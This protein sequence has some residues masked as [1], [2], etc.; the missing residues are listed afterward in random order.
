MMLRSKKSR[1]NLVTIL[2]SLVAVV[3]L[4]RA[5]GWSEVTEVFHRDFS[6][7]MLLQFLVLSLAVVLIYGYRW[8]ML[9]G[10]GLTHKASLV[11]SVISLGG[12]MFLP[13]RG[14]DVLRVHYSRQ[15]M[16]MPYAALLSR[17]F[18]EKLIDVFAIATVGVVAAIVLQD[19]RASAGHS[20]LVALTVTAFGAVVLATVT[21][22]YFSEAVL[23]RIK[24]VFR[25][26]GKLPLF[27][28]H[29]VHL[30][31]DASRSL[32]LRCTMPPFILTLA[33][34]FSVYALAYMLSAGFV[35][36]ALSYEDALLVLFA[37]TLGLMIPAAP[38]GVGTFHASVVSAFVILG[39]S[40]AE[41]LLVATSIHLLFFAAFA[42]PAALLCGS[43]R[44][45]H[46]IPR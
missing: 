41:G 1:R 42:L 23:R 16:G 36:V 37:G 24:P 8:R 14:G 22:K 35:G 45:S 25:F 29:V 30:V 17:M 31:R 28:R 18:V 15:A 12:N 27:E 33:M 2:I 26:A 34:W 11:S 43:W 10:D 19:Q 9:V 32:T 13:A 4:V 6:G 20:L 21:V 5:V 7:A 38:S 44:L 3:L 39:R 40:P 46:N